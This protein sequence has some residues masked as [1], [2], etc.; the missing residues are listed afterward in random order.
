MFSQKSA[1]FA[2]LIAL[3][4]CCAP[5]VKAQDEDVQALRLY[6]VDHHTQS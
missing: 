4:S 1:V 5:L 3:C 6:I 2:A